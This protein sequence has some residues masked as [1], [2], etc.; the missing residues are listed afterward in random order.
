MWRA[1]TSRDP[2]IQT[3][4]ASRRQIVEQS[5]KGVG[6]FVVATNYQAYYPLSTSAVERDDICVQVRYRLI[7]KLLVILIAILKSLNMAS[8]V[9]PTRP[10]K[11]AFV[12]CGCM[13]HD[14]P[15]N[16][17]FGGWSG[18]PIKIVVRITNKFL[19]YR[20]RA[21]GLFMRKWPSAWRKLLSPAG[22]G[23]YSPEHTRDCV[24]PTTL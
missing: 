3:F 19:V 5:L 6:R 24:A 11:S 20:E 4:A 2:Q 23:G 22:H 14:S 13:T 17:S 9:R 7:E 15:S 16:V 10:G 8:R 12:A 1:K 18:P 21:S